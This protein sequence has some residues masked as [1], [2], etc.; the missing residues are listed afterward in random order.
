MGVGN[1]SVKIRSSRGGCEQR[2]ICAPL[3]PWSRVWKW[4]HKLAKPPSPWVSEEPC[5]PDFPAHP[6]V[7]RGV[8]EGQSVAAKV[9]P[10]W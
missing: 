10:G 5:G 3:F 2:R 9:S 8:K 7:M 4:G 6:H 1:D